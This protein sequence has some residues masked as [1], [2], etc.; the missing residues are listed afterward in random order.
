MFNLTDIMQAAQ[1]GEATN[2]LAQRFGLTSTQAQAAVEALLPALSMGLQRTARNPYDLT[3]LAGL[4]GTGRHAETF[5]NSAVAFSAASVA[6]GN[7][8][9]N[10]IFGNKEVSRQV[11]SQ[12]AAVSGVGPDILKQM[13][14]VI[15]AMLMGGLFKSATNQGLGGLLGQLGGLFQQSGGFA[16]GQQGGGLPGGMGGFGFPQ[17]SPQ[18]SPQA[19]AAPQA[20][21]PGGT[22]AAPVDPTGGVMSGPLG[23]LLGSVLGSLLGGAAGASPA[24][25][26]QAA[27]PAKTEPP[28]QGQ[29]F[30]PSQFGLDQLTKMF[31]TGREVP[32]QHA[33]Q[34]Q[35]ILESLLGQPK[36]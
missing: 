7:D 34:L 11:A 28:Q 16:G 27:P 32:S 15:A 21:S 26:S 5:D 17:S 10:Q 9:L 4:L 2:N 29:P 14:P 1:G 36:R 8:V 24:A 33:D 30:D 18:S 23:G 12:A 22:G 31:Q 6:H 19:G 20:G 25:S 3:T 35:S 13:L